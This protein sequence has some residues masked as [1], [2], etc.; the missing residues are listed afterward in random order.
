MK[1]VFRCRLGDIRIIFVKSPLGHQDII[2][3]D[4]RKNVYRR[5]KK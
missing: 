1:G 4:F 2:D 3:V 5:L